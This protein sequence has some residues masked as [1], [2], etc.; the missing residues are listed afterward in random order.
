LL[1]ILPPWAR[2][3]IVE[4]RPQFGGGATAI[5][6]KNGARGSFSPQDSSAVIVSLS[7]GMVTVRAVSKS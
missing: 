2:G 1:S 7:N 6:P 5:T 3:W 4:T